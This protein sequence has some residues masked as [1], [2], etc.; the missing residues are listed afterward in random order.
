MDEPSVKF[1]AGVAGFDVVADVI[2]GQ[3]R[4]LGVDFVPAEVIVLD[5]P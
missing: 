2:G 5:V 3:L 4:N 1:T